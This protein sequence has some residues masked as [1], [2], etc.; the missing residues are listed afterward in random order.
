[1]ELFNVI[2]RLAFGATLSLAAVGVWHYLEIEGKNVELESALQDVDRQRAEAA[3]RGL[4]ARQAA[5]AAQMGRTAEL[6]A[7][8]QTG[9]FQKLTSIHVVTPL[10]RLSIRK[11]YE[12]REPRTSLPESIVQNAGH[13][14]TTPRQGNL[15][16]KFA[17]SSMLPV[18]LYVAI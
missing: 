11:C 3:A 18:P 1:M 10:N 7:N 15:Q 6:F 16:E 17:A 5:Y 2:T 9:L 8:R 13:C 4:R 12:V 14:L